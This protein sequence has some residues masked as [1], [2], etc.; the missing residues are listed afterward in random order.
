MKDISMFKGQLGWK[1]F[2]SYLVIIVVGTGVLA[3]TAQFLASDALARHIASMQAV[4]GD[5]PSLAADLEANFQAAVSEILAAGTLAAFVAAVSV[6]TFT[7]KRIVDP[8]QAMMKAS[9]RIAAGDYHQRV[10][11]PGQDELGALAQAFNRMAATL[12]QTEQRRLRL[13]GDVAHEL[14]TPL[15]SIMGTMEGLLDSVLAADSTTFLGVQREVA[16]LQ[17]LVYDLEELSRA[18]AGQI[19]IDRDSIILG[20]LVDSVAERLKL[21]FEEKGV[22][23]SMQIPKSLPQVWA[24]SSRI[25]QVLLNLLGNALQYTPADGQVTVRAWHEAE[26]VFVAVQDTGIGISAAHL[27]HI[28]ERF[29][30]VDKSRSRVGGGSGIGLT[31]A[32]YLVEAHDGRIWVTSPGPGSGCTFTFSLPV[33]S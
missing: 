11:V 20:D 32:K 16:R 12:E 28:F 2:L 25:S 31:I 18:E 7:T 23:L 9:Q 1:L 26:E 8:I 27:P 29:Y 22:R 4:L 10:Y 19:P 21:Q 5:N 13:I 14:R 17:R 24:D 6:S 15:S 30:R 3:G 33:V